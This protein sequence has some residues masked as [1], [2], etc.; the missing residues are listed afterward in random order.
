MHSV[1]ETFW[2]RVRNTLPWIG[3]GMEC[4]GPFS[5]RQNRKIICLHLRARMCVYCVWVLFRR[6]SSNLIKRTSLF[7]Y[8]C[9]LQEQPLL[10]EYSRMLTVLACWARF[11]D[12]G[13][14]CLP[15][16]LW[17]QVGMGWGGEGGSVCRG[18]LCV[19]STPESKLLRWA[20]FLSSWCV[21]SHTMFHRHSLDN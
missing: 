4:L 21:S 20:I 3:V 13:G 1:T 19:L 10:L 5:V 2:G 7:P 18:C 12:C 15:P 9:H 16:G 11:W 17:W 14:G 6:I 8:W